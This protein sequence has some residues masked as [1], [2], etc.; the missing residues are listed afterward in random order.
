MAAE[1]LGLSAVV[2]ANLDSSMVAASSEPI[3]AAEVAFVD[4]S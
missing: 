2:A 3:A 1:C 4:G